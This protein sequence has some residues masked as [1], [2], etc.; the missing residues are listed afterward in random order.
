[1]PDIPERMKA[2]GRE[3]NPVFDPAEYLYRRFLPNEDPD[4]IE[5]DMIEM[6]DMSCL[7]ELYA[8]PEHA[9][10]H[11]ECLYDGWGVLQVRVREVPHTVKSW[12][13]RPAHTPRPDN[14]AHTDIRCHD[15]TSGKEVHITDKNSELI[16]PDVHLQFREKMLEYTSVRLRPGDFNWGDAD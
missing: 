7:R 8:L 4:E 16:D 2:N 13:I 1:M 11:R 15:A 9:I 6:P 3:A 14:Y 5:I 10:W 12:S